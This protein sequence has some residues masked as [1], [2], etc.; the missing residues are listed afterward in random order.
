[1]KKTQRLVSNMLV[2]TL[3]AFATTTIPSGCQKPS[4]SEQ[5][6]TTRTVD[7]R[8]GNG[9][10]SALVSIEFP[11][12]PDERL[13][14]SI[15]EQLNEQLGG[16]YEGDY[17]D[18]DSFARCYASHYMD[19]ISE[20]RSEFE[21]YEPEMPF[22]RELTIT[23]GYETD[24]LVTFDLQTYEFSGGAHGGGLAYGITF[25]KSDGRRMDQNILSI[26]HDAVEWNEMLKRGL[27]EYFEV[28][29]ESD[30]EGFL[31]DVELYNIPMPSC[32]VSF[33]ANGLSF[34]YQQY[35]IAAYACGR[36]NFVIPY[37]KLRPFL[38]VTGR[39]LLDNDVRNP[40]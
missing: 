24:R 27:M 10:D 33:A 20:M 19:E 11:T 32:G 23:R 16:L 4:N 36:P 1:M 8:N 6:T 26:S 28:K 5:Q 13:N 30:L 14:L 18:C 37:D 39:R 3:L 15:T 35:E 31:M 17:A 2:A 21:G 40:N 25:R 22:E 34:V 7:V 9:E 38:N 12:Y 29:T